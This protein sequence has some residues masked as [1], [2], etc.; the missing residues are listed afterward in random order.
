M[1]QIIDAFRGSQSFDG[2]MKIGALASFNFVILADG[3]TTVLAA[4]N[5]GRNIT[6]AGMRGVAGAIAILLVVFNLVFFFLALTAYISGPGLFQWQFL[7]TVVSIL[8]ACYLR[9]FQSS[10][11]EPD[12]AAIRRQEDQ[13]VE[14]LTRNSH[15]ESQD[16]EGTKL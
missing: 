2:Q 10:E 3:I 14:K 7:L 16:D 15:K 6:A 5:S 9:C 1:P 11:W 8:T 4:R 12:V 13:D